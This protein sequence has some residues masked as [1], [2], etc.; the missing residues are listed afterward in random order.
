MHRGLGL[1]SETAEIRAVLVELRWRGR[2]KSRHGS[3][4][5]DE[6]SESQYIEAGKVQVGNSVFGSWPTLKTNLVY[7]VQYNYYQAKVYLTCV[8]HKLSQLFNIAF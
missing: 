7:V 3:K 2:K 6:K 8:L 5:K 4:R 1:S